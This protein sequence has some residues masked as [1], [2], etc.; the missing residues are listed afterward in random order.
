MSR[1]PLGKCLAQFS[2]NC[3]S[4]KLYVTMYFFHSID[5]GAPMVGLPLSRYDISWLGSQVNK[6][7]T[8]KYKLRAMKASKANL[9][10]W[11]LFDGWSL[12]NPNVELERAWNV[13][14]V[15]DVSPMNQ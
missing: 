3:V 11:L 7:H 14:S 9:Q 5:V 10:I 1:L 2:V 15:R 8:R 12:L 13:W 4:C 6:A